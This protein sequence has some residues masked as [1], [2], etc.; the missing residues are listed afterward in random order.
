MQVDFHGQYYAEKVV[1]YGLYGATVIGFLIGS[2]TDSL[3]FSV[4]LIIG[5]AI[6]LSLLII[7]SWPFMR[8]HPVKWAKK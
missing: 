2:L 4:G 3:L 8:K 7:P 6:L 5:T 1:Y